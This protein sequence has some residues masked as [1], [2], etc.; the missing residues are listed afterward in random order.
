[1]RMVFNNGVELRMGAGIIAKLIR[2]IEK[3]GM[4]LESGGILIGTRSIDGF[5]YEITDVTFPT[6]NDKQCR[7]SFK[8]SK[9]IANVAINK[10]WQRSNGKENY[11]GEWHT[12]NEPDPKPSKTDKRTVKHLAKH[13]PHPFEHTFLIILGNSNVHFVGMIASQGKSAIE[14]W[15]NFYVR[16]DLL[17]S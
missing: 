9:T 1:M 16:P 12:H 11:L 2:Y 5:T 15:T 13:G 8:R 10:A 6:K 3:N 17:F 14:N 7:F 4:E